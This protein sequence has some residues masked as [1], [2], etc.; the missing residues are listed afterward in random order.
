MP[1]A[2]RVKAAEGNL[3]RF[4]KGLPKTCRKPAVSTWYWKRSDCAKYFGFNACAEH[5]K[6]VEET[7][8]R[9]GQYK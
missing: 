6:I 7:E 3:C 4:S 9:L 2:M 8:K 5:D 1:E